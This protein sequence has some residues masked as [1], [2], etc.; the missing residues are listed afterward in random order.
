MKGLGRVIMDATELRPLLMGIIVAVIVGLVLTAPISSAALCIMLNLSGLAAGAAVAGCSAQM[1][2]FA[3]ASYKENG[4]GGLLAQGIGTSMLQ[5]SNIIKHP[6][7]LLPATIASAVAGPMSTCIFKMTNIPAGAGMGTSGLVGQIGAF[8]A[9][10]F[11]VKVLIAV[12]T[13]HIAVPAVVAFLT[14]RFLRETGKI[15]YGDYLIEL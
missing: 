9:M 4:V 3:V 11:S 5:V 7:I 6:W 8:T 14:D 1:I 10:G 13:V 2:G 15:Q 12:L